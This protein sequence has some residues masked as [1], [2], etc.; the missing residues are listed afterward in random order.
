MWQVHG[1][2]SAY[3]MGI[4]F[5]VSP[6]VCAVEVGGCLVSASITSSLDTKK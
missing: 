6:G 1:G 3:L 5:H 2:G 4:P